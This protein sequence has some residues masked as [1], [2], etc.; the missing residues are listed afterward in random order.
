MKAAEAAADKEV[1]SS[2]TI[3]VDEE[4]NGSRKRTKNKR[5]QGY[6]TNHG[7]YDQTLLYSKSTDT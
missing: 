3:Q 4:S 7:I 2:Q 6:E 1:P 5:L